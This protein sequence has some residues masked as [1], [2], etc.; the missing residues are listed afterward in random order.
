MRERIANMLFVIH[1]I[2][3]PGLMGGLIFVLLSSLDAVLFKILAGILLYIG[4]F[5]F[6]SI[7]FVMGFFDGKQIAW[8]PAL[9]YVALL[10]ILFVS[11]P[12]PAWIHGVLP[13]PH[14]GLLIWPSL[15]ALALGIL[16]HPAPW[17]GPFTRRR[18]WQ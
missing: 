9:G 5:S 16:I 1:A 17:W 3:F 6:S 7:R 12:W 14:V 13:G 18:R 2:T 11:R 10:P 4:L 15:A 8:I